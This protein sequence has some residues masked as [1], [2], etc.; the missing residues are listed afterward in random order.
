MGEARDKT[1]QSARDQRA[2]HPTHSLAV[3]QV[4]AA[5]ALRYVYD[6]LRVPLSHT[7][8]HE[9]IAQD[10]LAGESHMPMVEVVDRGKLTPAHLE[11]IL[12]N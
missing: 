6:T 5:T 10:S 1:N 9:S 11:L 4:R 3:R 12:R 8:N 7:D 2:R